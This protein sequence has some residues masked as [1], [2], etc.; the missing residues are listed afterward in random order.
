MR[1]RHGRHLDDMIVV[2][3]GGEMCVHEEMEI[4]NVMELVWSSAE[5]SA[6]DFCIS[7]SCADMML[8]MSS[9]VFSGM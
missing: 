1:G 6:P 5:L 7:L 2:Y 3:V 8:G 4:W 9:A